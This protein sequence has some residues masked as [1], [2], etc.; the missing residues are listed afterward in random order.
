MLQFTIK[1]ANY[2]NLRSRSQNQTL[3]SCTKHLTLCSS[4]NLLLF[5]SAL[6][7]EV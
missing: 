1:V 7:T 6:S 4:H 5:P 2:F 3:P